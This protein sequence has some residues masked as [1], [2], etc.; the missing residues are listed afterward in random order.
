MKRFSLLLL[1]CCALCVSCAQMDEK[2]SPD[3]RI[4]RAQKAGVLRVASQQQFAAIIDDMK[5]ADVFD[6]TEMPQSR[7]GE[8][9]IDEQ[10]VSLRQHLIEQGLREFTD[11]ELAQIIADSLE[12]EPEDS[13]IIDPYMMAVLNENREVQIGDKIFRYIDEGLLIYE[14]PKFSFNGEISVGEAQ[15]DPDNIVFPEDA[16]TLSQGEKTAVQDIDGNLADLIG[17][18]YIRGDFIGY[19]PVGDDNAGGS[20]GGSDDENDD[21]EGGEIWFR[22]FDDIWVPESHIGKAI[23]KVGGSQGGWLNSTL[24]ALT[25]SSNIN[26]KITKKFDSRHRMKMRMYE[27]NYIIYSA[28]GMTLRM[29]KRRFRI[30]WRRKAQE[31]RYGWSAMELKYKFNS[32]IFKDPEKNADGSFVR[33]KYPTA[34]IKDFP[35]AKQKGVLFYVPEEKYNITNGD[36]DVVLNQGL[37]SVI[38]KIN[39]W[40]LTPSNAS[41]LDAPRGIFTVVDKG[42]SMHVIYPNGQERETNDGR[43]VLR[44]DKQWFSGS[45]DV[46]FGYGYE[47]GYKV[48]KIKFEPSK[49][50]DIHRGCI[51][52][53]VKYQGEWRICMIKTE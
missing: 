12:Y 46:N 29:Q 31:M 18:E 14:A 5:N 40:E 16:P 11:D 42:K 51:I 50:V 19:R 26:V 41:Y 39:A 35:C 32:E 43:E 3:T 1:L 44:W 20:G 6:V 27:Q 23:Y 30:W 10:F 13:L 36:C 34:I 4:G 33:E 25:G 17:I 22:F 28:C 24:S 53:A 2:V 9:S 21:E 52:G 48:E 15:F 8:V 38:D 37:A 45:F 49:D 7:N 47:N